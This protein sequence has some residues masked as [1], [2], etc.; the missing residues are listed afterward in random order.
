MKHLRLIDMIDD[1]VKVVGKVCVHLA[2]VHFECSYEG[3]AE[4]HAHRYCKPVLA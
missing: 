3:P 1:A 4:A 2:G